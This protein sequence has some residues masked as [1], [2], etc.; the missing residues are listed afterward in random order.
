MGRLDAVL[1][2]SLLVFVACQ[3]VRVKTDQRAPALPSS[4][5][6]APETVV[7]PVKPKTYSE[8]VSQWKSDEDVLKWLQEEFKFD[9]AR[10]KR[11]EGT[12]PP[13]RTPEETFQFRSGIYV[14]V[15]TF[16]REALHRIN[17]TY[18]ARIVVLLVRPSVLNYYVCSFRKGGKLFIFDFGTPYPSVTG[19]H[20]PYNSLE[21]LRIFYEKTHPLKRKIEAIRALP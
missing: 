14:D 5:A 1:C 11:F 3:P 19:M 7:A 15:A 8:A 13:P 21:E 9:T 12:L 16:A 18:Q 17:P 20:G 2:L 4:S 6:P 10:F